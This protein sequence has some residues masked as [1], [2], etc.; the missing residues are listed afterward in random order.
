MCSPRGAL[1]LWAQ[2]KKGPVGGRL[3]YK[4][5]IGSATGLGGRRLPLC[6][7]HPAWRVRPLRPH[8]DVPSQP[9]L[10]PLRLAPPAGR[11]QEQAQEQEE[12]LGT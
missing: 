9:G 12:G 4:R 6:T 7:V 1:P 8:W 5:E 2:G 3:V 10:V 11:L